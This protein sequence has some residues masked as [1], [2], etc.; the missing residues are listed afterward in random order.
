MINAILTELEQRVADTR[1]ELDGLRGVD[2]YSEIRLRGQLDGLRDAINAVKI[3]D[4][5]SVLNG[6]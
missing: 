2:V 1:A 4:I 5:R 6:A 3:V